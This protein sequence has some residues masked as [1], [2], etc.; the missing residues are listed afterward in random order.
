[1][2]IAIVAAALLLTGLL[3]VPCPSPACSLCGGYAAK[4]PF[5]TEY[6]NAS[7]VV[8]GTLAK[9]QLNGNTGAGTTELIVDKVLRGDPRLRNTPVITLPRYFTVL[10]SKD[11][12][13]FVAL[14]DDKLRFYS[15]RTGY[16]PALLDFL[17]ASDAMK[18]KP[19]VQ[20]LGHFAKYLDS[21]DPAVAEDAFLLFA[22]ANDREVMEAAGSLKPD[23]FRKLVKDSRVDA[24]RLS[25]FAFLL[26]ATGGP[27]D[28]D[29]LWPLLQKPDDRAVKALEGIVSGYI[30][31]RPKEGWAWTNATLGDPR[32]PFVVRW[33]TVR[34]LHFLYNARPEETKKQV[35]HTL[36][37]MVPHGELAD[38]AIS[39]L[40]KWKLWDHT[41]LILKQ[42]GR[43]SH[44]APIVRNAIL[45]Y[46]LTCPLPA[47]QTFVAD[48][49]RHEPQV[50]RELEEDIRF[51]QQGR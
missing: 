31:R 34:A 37:L 8:C 13:R 32:R 14:F 4:F 42:Y 48:R 35:V 7:A 47:A 16:T 22:Q 39:D 45:R 20:A 12:P 5:V 10:N 33:G 6:W 41:E 17:V 28:A 24:E 15:G 2:R 3:L 9:P 11:P 36:G 19:R 40:Q 27:T 23:V 44:A 18:G 29:V 26:G 46:A 43:P 49:R 21:A 38:V 25:L 1:M 30:L 51:E 50:I